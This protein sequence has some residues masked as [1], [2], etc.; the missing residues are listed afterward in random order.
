MLQI[1]LRYLFQTLLHSLH[2]A[3]VN[4][5]KYKNRLFEVLTMEQGA[6]DFLVGM[7]GDI[8]SM[9]VLAVSIIFPPCTSRI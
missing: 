7:Q 6:H 5:Q 4:Y 3:T 2:T 8:S 9:Q 1:E